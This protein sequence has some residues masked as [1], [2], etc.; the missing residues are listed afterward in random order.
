MEKARLTVFRELAADAND[1]T[2]RRGLLL[3]TV[4]NLVAL[5]GIVSGSQVDLEGGKYQDYTVEALCNSKSMQNGHDKITWDNFKC[6]ISLL[7]K[8]NPGSRIPAF[9]VLNDT[10][11]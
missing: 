10:F 2:K 9:L 4:N 3:I 7:H 11:F 6:E 5:S 1:P 8:L